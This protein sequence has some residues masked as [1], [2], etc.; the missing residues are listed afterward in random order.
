MLPYILLTVLM[1]RWVNIEY[2]RFLAGDK[3]TFKHAAFYKASEKDF[4]FQ[5]RMLWVVL[6]GQLLF[7]INWLILG[8]QHMETPADILMIISPIAIYSIALL[9]IHRVLGQTP[10]E[11]P[12]PTEYTKL[13]SF[14]F[15]RFILI[16]QLILWLLCF[17]LTVLW[18]L[19]HF[20]INNPL[21]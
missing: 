11:N 20:E 18:A 21:F 14:L 19:A 13:Q 16:T 17:I 3:V 4:R 5:F 15:N 10:H 6:V 8:W 7:F 9:Y 12:P 2:K 1:L